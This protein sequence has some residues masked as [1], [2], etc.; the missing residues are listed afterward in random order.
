MVVTIKG[1]RQMDATLDGEDK[2]LQT[3]RQINGT[4]QKLVVRIKR[5]K[6]TNRQTQDPWVKN[7]M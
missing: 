5:Y 1:Y 7:V 3:D 2:T 6:E 4:L